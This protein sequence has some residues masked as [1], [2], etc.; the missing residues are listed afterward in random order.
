[1]AHGKIGN[2][3]L[4]CIQRCWAAVHEIRSV[5]MCFTERQKAGFTLF[6]AWS[7]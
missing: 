6:L 7:S 2:R 3:G 4:H 5:E 1:M